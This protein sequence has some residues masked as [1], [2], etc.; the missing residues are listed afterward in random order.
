MISVKDRKEQFVSG[1]TG[2]SIGEINLITFVAL[3]AYF[4]WNL[5]NRKSSDGNVPLIVDFLLNWCGIL[6]STTLY[7]NDPLGLNI[8]ILVPCA[9]Y[10]LITD[11]ARP[12]TRTTSS[13]KKKDKNSVFKISKKPFITAYRSSML[14][15]TCLCILAVDFPLFPRRFAKVET[16]G[17]SLMDLGVGSF[18]FS[19]GIVSSRAL[20]RQKI[21][22]NKYPLTVKIVKAL[23]SSA[24]LLVLGFIRLW[25]V[26][27]LE[28]QEHVT[29]YG[30]H[31]NFFFTLAC[32]PLV[33]ACVDEVAAYIPRALIAIAI[34]II[35]ELLLSRDGFLEYLIS[36]PRDSLINANREGMFSL[37]GYCSIYLWGQN[38]GFLVLGNQPTVNNLY[39]PS[40]VPYNPKS[41][42]NSTW[43]NLTS[44]SPL[45]GLVT[46]ETIFV[47]VTK[48]VFKYYYFNVSR[49]F[50]NAP[51][52]LWVV[53]YNL[54][55]LALYS[56]V[57]SIFG[58]TSSYSTIPLTLEAINANGLAIFLLA[59]VL[60]GLI[61]MNLTTIDTTPVEGM[62]VLV[63]YAIV[64]AAVS[65][66]MYKKK[67]YIK[68]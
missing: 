35:P 37:F 1:L 64:I 39:K 4:C 50:A 26:K 51:Y 58:N 13:S 21:E 61:N 15:V 9:A 47:F 68:L 57:D 17:T 44:A 63:S 53:T 46:L 52:V 62:I 54:G 22:G 59:N 5:I 7:S 31:W 41:T 10:Y 18:V 43:V 25:S 67:I 27:G 3:V 66:E 36:S 23:R 16:W 2:S 12:P 14:V 24:T 19:N 32:I 45:K 33:V 48:L 65:I 8:L 28:Y 60:T 42:G 38:T 55:M 30:V 34:S 11:K 6:L 49:R 29:E 40:V 20:L 56:L